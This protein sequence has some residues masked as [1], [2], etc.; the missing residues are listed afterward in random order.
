MR[1]IWAV[2]PGLLLC[3]GLALAGQALAAALQLPVPGAVLG[4]LAYLL[5]LLLVPAARHTRAG[6]ALLVRWIGAMLVPAL[7]GLH[8]A[9]PLLAAAA[10]PVMLLLVGTTLVTAL[11]TAWLYRL[12]GGR[13]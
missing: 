6:A 11:A 4:L 5:L 8:A 7:I 12:A 13:G 9:L 3:V 10:L 2:V 1:G